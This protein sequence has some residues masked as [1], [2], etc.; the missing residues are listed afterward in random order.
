MQIEEI[1]KALQEEKL[2]GWLFFDHHQRDPLAYRILGLGSGR[3]A[4]RRWYYFIPA[5]GEPRGLVHAIESGALA[6][7]PGEMR[8]Y[9]SWA[10]QT[11]GISFLLN[12]SNRVAMQYSPNCAIPYVSLVDGGTLELVRST[13]VEVVSSANLVQLF[14]ARW[15]AEQLEMH[16]EA[17]RRV[18]R[19]RAEAFHKIG[20]ALNAGETITEWQV[21]RFIREGFENAGLVTDHGPIVA[22]NA[23][24]SDPHY[25]PQPESSLPIRP[26]DAV[27]IDLWAKLDKPCAVFYDVTWTGYCGSHPPAAL[28]KIF[29]VVTAGRDRAIEFVKHAISHHQLIHGF[30]VDDVTRGYID[31]QGYGEY[32]VHRTGHSIGQEVHGTSANMDNLETHDDRR[33]IARTCFSI[34]PGVYLPDFGIR[35]EVNMYIGPTEAQVTG[36]I[37]RELVRIGC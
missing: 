32:F 29:A 3:L 14:D 2:D 18:D 22:V 37:Q 26:N 8:V 6:G 19:V 12:G 35:S 31:K 11:D 21:N 27:L 28:Q 36:E 15:T 30:E 23:H 13:G 24:M 10:G 17:G 1:Q 5:Q 34:E 9:S 4:S 20:A 25:E 16:L 33:I 7:L